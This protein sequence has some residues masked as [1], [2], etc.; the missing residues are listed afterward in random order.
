[1]GDGALHLEGDFRGV[2][3]ELDPIVYD[4]GDGGEG[5]DDGE[6]GEVAEL[7]DHFSQ[8]G[9]DVVD[10][11]F[12]FVADAGKEFCFF[13][14][15][16]KTGAGGHTSTF[17][18]ALRFDLL[19]LVKTPAF[20]DGNDVFEGEVDDLRGDGEIDDLLTKAG[21]V[22]FKSCVFGRGGEMFGGGGER[23]GGEA[24]DVEIGDDE[25]AEGDVDESGE[26]DAQ[27][28]GYEVEDEYFLSE[29]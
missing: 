16:V 8:V 21:G 10:V 23:A 20:E 27:V 12:G 4:E 17:R 5:P 11:E 22:D 26:E 2:G 28:G 29:S 1:M 24:E 19:V 3:A 13:R 6:E 25:A 7:D 15:V 14:L 18:S 9:G